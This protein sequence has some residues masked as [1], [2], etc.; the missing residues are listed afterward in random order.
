MVSAENK[1]NEQGELM[2]VEP[3]KMGYVGCGFMAQHVHLPNFATARECDLVALAEVRPQL[4]QQVAARFGIPK[5]YS[6]HQQLAEDPDIEAVGVSAGFAQQGEIAADLLHAGKHVFMEKP[7]AISLDQANR[8]LGAAREG[9]ARLMIGY[10]KRYDEGNIYAR[11]KIS[12][13]KQSGEMG[14]AVYARNHGYCGDWTAGLD[15][16]D[17]ITTDEPQPPA[18]YDEQL[19][20]WLPRERAREYVGYLQQYTHNINLLRYLLGVDADAQVKCVDLD[21]DGMTGNVTLDVGGVRA[22]VESASTEHHRWDE[23][24]QVYF[25]KG[26]VHV[27]APP[28]MVPST[29]S[30]VE[31]YRGGG[32]NT[33]EYPVPGLSTSWP[34]RDEALG[35]LRALQTGEQFRSSGEDTLTDV[36]LCEEIYRQYLG[37]WSL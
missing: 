23:H 19:P 4:G 26:W 35:F 13:W 3:I 37:I 5:V 32:V 10:M 17:F 15:L 20:E 29:R 12:E 2:T 25:R 7:M 1:H 27:W 18:P 28:M 8:I 33:Y 24:T 30:T 6:S 16:T 22:V 21:A 14:V 34:Y 31:V 11:Q 36:R 9:R